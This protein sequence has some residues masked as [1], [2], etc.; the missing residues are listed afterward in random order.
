MALVK[1]AN[2]GQE[3]SDKAET[4]IHCNAK[5]G[6]VNTEKVKVKKEKKK[7]NKKIIII[8][9]L[10]VL[11]AIGIF[12]YKFIV[13]K[14]TEEKYAEAVNYFNQKEYDKASE[15]LEHKFLKDYG[16]SDDYRSAIAMMKLLEEEKYEEVLTQ[17][18]GISDEVG[19]KY[20]IKNFAKNASNYKKQDYKAIWEDN[21]YTTTFYND[22]EKEMVYDGIYNY[23]LSVYN[24]GYYGSSKEM[25]EK[26]KDYKNSAEILNDKYFQLIG[27]NYNYSTSYGYTWGYMSILFYSYGDRIN[28]NVFTQ[29][30]FNTNLPKGNEY[31]YRIKNNQLIVAGDIVLFDIVSF[32]G[33]NLVIRDGNN[34]FTLTKT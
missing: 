8:V 27:N 11:L 23:A 34:K 25:F 6:K 33:Y 16:L 13:N 7:G 19:V 26:I 24:D 29:S 30:L 17:I 28:Y 22:K 12:G 14:I 10:I 32:D 5:V 31:T 20:S 18:D 2:C 4:C 9:I 1:C 3:I 21:K 15:V